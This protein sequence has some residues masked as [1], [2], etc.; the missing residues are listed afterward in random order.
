MSTRD[1]KRPTLKDVAA[2]AGVDASLVSRVVSNDQGISIPDST[3]QRILDAVAAVNYRPSA[4]ARGLRTQKLSTLG[5]IIPDL[6]NPV[7]AP[8]AQGA[9]AR[10]AEA[11]FAL[12]LASD[13]EGPSRRAAHDLVRLLAE[14]RVDGLLVASGSNNDELLA[15]LTGVDKPVVLVNRAIS[16]IPS[17]TVDDVA[18]ARLATRHLIDRGHTTIAH[19]GGPL[20]VD[21]TTRRQAGFDQ[22][23]ADIE[24]VERPVTVHAANWGAA[25]G[26]RAGLELLADRRGATAIFAA[27]VTLAIGLYRAAHELGLAVPNDLSIVALHDYDLAAML[28]PSLT[29]VAMPLFELGVLAVE[30]LLDLIDGG[31]PGNRI[32]T[33]PPV[34]VERNSVTGH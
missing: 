28:V 11:G 30:Q 32:V 13:T 29:T 3:R 19:L 17:S 20:G 15:M 2:L 8:I 22:A 5:L 9:Q 10:A 23:I 34:L 12:L 25:E 21:T 33:S 16:G 18:G 4:T 14:D 7:Y 24:T 1:G 31:P 6:T 27:N 26:Y